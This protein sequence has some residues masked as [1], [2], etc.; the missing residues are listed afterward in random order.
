MAR[1]RL[2]LVAQ[3]RLRVVVDRIVPARRVASIAKSKGH[4]DADALA[5]RV[6][7]TG[8]VLAGPFEGLR[9]PMTTSSGSTAPYFAGT[10]EEELIEYV[11]AM[12]ARRPGVVVDVGAGEGY[13]AVGLAKRLPNAQ[14]IAYDIDVVARRL[15]AETAARNE[16]ANVTV[17]GR[18]TPSALERVLVPGT[19]VVCDC[20]GYEEVLLDPSAAPSLR[21]STMVVELHDVFAPGITQTFMDRFGTSHHITLVPFEERSLT[22]RPQLAHLSQDDR[23]A[24]MAEGRPSEPWPMH[25]AIATPKGSVQAHPS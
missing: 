24:A 6:S 14:V 25:W 3:D 17:R 13:Y 22:G 8:M 23:R 7:P 11:E 18:V 20:E 5:R 1:D 19:L 2:P 21:T 9:L 4:A 12:I 16:V 15:C 10:Y